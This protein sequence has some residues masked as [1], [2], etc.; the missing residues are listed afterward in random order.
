MLRRHTQLTQQA[1]MDF[2]QPTADSA[3]IATTTGN[4]HRCELAVCWR[5]GGAAEGLIHSEEKK[6]GGSGA[7]R[8]RKTR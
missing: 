5:S 7:G 1:R 6:M 2:F 8:W 4:Q 3:F